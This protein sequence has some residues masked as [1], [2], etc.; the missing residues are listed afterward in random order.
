MQDE[1]ILDLFWQ[2]KESAIDETERKYRTYLHCIA[3]SILGDLSDCQETVNDTLL[4]A[5]NSIPPHRP[6]VLSTYLGKIV[7]QTA[8][9]RIN[10][11][12]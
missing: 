3:F 4:K 6:A 1:K 11:V 8:I 7:R 9:D 10:L 12:F 2:R 5:W